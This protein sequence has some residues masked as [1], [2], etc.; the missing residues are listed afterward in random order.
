MTDYSTAYLNQQHQQQHQ[1]QNVFVDNTPNILDLPS[2]YHSSTNQQQQQQQQHIQHQQ[3]Y[4]THLSSAPDHSTNPYR[5][6]YGA[7]AVAAASWRHFSNSHSLL[8]QTSSQA[9]NIIPSHQTLSSQSNAFVPL[10][11]PNSTNTTNNNN[12]SFNSNYNNNSNKA[13][14]ASPASSTGSTT[15]S[16]N[17]QDDQL[18]LTNASSQQRASNSSTPF[19]TLSASEKRKQRRIR[20]TFSSTQ[21]KELEKAF[22]E[23]HYPDIYTRE[24]IAIKIDLTEARVQVWFQ[25]RRAK[26]RKHERQRQHSSKSSHSNQNKNKLDYSKFI[27]L[28]FLFFFV[29]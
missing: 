4:T 3:F 9:C 1:L 18:Y 10:N 23:T 7:A 24:E 27:T 2:N 21:L 14:P 15:S 22:Q 28:S 16:S 11:S 25:N 5:N 13:Y 12:T 8:E 19:S 6:V 26:F 20:T 17:Q 29:Y